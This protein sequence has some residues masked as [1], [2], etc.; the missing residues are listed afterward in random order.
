MNIVTIDSKICCFINEH[1]NWRDILKNEYKINIKEEYPFAIFNYEINCDFSNP[2]VQEARGIIIDIQDCNVV[3]W[4]FRKF[5]NYNESYADAI[6]WSTARVENKIDGSIIKLWWN[7]YLEKWQFS[8]NSTINASDALANQMTQESFL[9]VIRKADNYNDL[10]LRL[11]NLNENFTFIF[12]LVSPETQI[13]V[14]YPTAHLYHIGTRNN[15]T[16]TENSVSIGIER[17]KEYSLRSLDDC[18]NASIQLNQSEDSQVHNVKKEGFVV[19]DCKWNRIKV[20]SPDY[21]MLHHMSSNSNFSK[22]RIISLLRNEAIS[23]YDISKDFPNFSHY[24]KYYDFKMT[25]LNYQAKVFCD[26]TDKIYEEYSH[27]RKTVANIIKK[28][29]LAAIGFMHLDSGKSGVEILD[30]LPLQKYC[31]YIPDY[32]PERLSELFYQRCD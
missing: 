32:R 29:R 30:S 11:P 14:K 15:I 13:V 24:F 21:L 18:I 5:G 25:E 9:D 17:P 6:D 8:T 31:K 16:G 1:T 20:K 19:V 2:I 23:V 12:E 27:E 28:H 10:L 26:L 22:E 7:K 3:C 4:P